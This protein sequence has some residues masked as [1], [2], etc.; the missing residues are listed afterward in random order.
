MMMLYQEDID[1]IKV[2]T[3]CDIGINE[4]EE[5]G[6]NGWIMT[7]FGSDQARESAH[8]AV[9][10]LLNQRVMEQQNEVPPTQGVQEPPQMQEPQTIVGNVGEAMPFTM[11]ATMDPAQAATVPTMTSVLQL[12]N[13]FIS[14]LFEED[15]AQIQQ[16]IGCTCQVNESEQGGTVGGW[17]IT[18]FGSE[19]QRDAGHRA[20]EDLLSQRMLEM[21]QD[22]GEGGA[23]SVPPT[24]IPV[25]Q[26]DG[27][28]NGEGEQQMVPCTILPIPYAYLKKLFNLDAIQEVY[29]CTIT[30]SPPEKDST[31]WQLALYGDVSQRQK[32]HQAIEDTLNAAMA[33][34][35]QQVTMEQR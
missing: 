16:E 27:A 1:Q 26:Q 18:L 15:I 19:E 23:L 21:Q 6:A 29:G 9:E 22:E 30:V 28:I 11:P 20:I 3:A 17:T 13:D 10:D 32:A 34:E 8:R 12:S 5:G 35:Q 7:L 4:S 2:D 33:Q 31:D 25:P 24:D 14:M